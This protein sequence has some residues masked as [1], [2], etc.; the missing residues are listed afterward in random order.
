MGMSRKPQTLTDQIRRAV[1]ADDRSRYALC[2]A[3]GIDKS[4]MSRF[5]ADK[6]FLSKESLNRLA[7]VLGIQIADSKAHKGKRKGW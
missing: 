6:G 3:T 7:A 2:K 4:V 5:M 1:D